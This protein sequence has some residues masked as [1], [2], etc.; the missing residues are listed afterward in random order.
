MSGG[1]SRR[2]REGREAFSRGG[3]PDVRNPYRPGTS[4]ASDWLDGWREAKRDDDIV[5]KHEQ[6]A[7]LDDIDKVEEFARLYNL[8]KEQ[9]L[10]T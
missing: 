1:P 2:R 10:I 9:G 5:I 6:Q 7:A 8:A 4:Y 3:D